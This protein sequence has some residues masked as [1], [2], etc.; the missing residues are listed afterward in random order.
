MYDYCIDKQIK[1]HETLVYLANKYSSLPWMQKL[2]DD[3]VSEWTKR[4]MRNDEEIAFILNEQIEYYLDLE[5]ISKQ[6]G[7]RADV[8]AQCENKWA[9]N[10]VGKGH[11]WQM[12]LHCYKEAMGTD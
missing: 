2:I 7:Y 3:E 10:A 8:R 6:P 12:T 11:R 9:D 4:D 5:Y 1:G